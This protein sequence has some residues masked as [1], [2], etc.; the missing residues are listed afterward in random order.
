MKN[1]GFQIQ[2]YAE[3]ADI[4]LCSK[5]LSVRVRPWL[6]AAAMG[7]IQPFFCQAPTAAKAKR[8]KRVSSARFFFKMSLPLANATQFRK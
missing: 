1:L 4:K 8:L 2:T 7:R 3:D 6:L 5:T